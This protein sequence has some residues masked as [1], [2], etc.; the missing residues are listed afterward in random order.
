MQSTSKITIILDIVAAVLGIIYRIVKFIVRFIVLIFTAL[1][2]LSKQ[3]RTIS[4]GFSPKYLLIIAFSFVMFAPG[5]L[6]VKAYFDENKQ[7]VTY[8]TLFGD[9]PVW[10][11]NKVVEKDKNKALGNWSNR[12][13][14]KRWLFAHYNYLLWKGR[15]SA[16]LE[17]RVFRSPWIQNLPFVYKSYISESKVDQIMDNFKAF[18]SYYSKKGID[19]YVILVCWST[20]YYPERLPCDANGAKN[21]IKYNLD[22]QTKLHDELLKL[23]IGNSNLYSLFIKNRDKY[24]FGQWYD[25]HWSPTAAFVA[26]SEMTKWV[27]KKYNTSPVDWEDFKYY[28]LE[29]PLYQSPYLNAHGFNDF[30]YLENSLNLHAM[31]SNPVYPDIYEK[32][33]KPWDEVEPISEFSG[34]KVVYNDIFSH[35]VNKDALTD[36]KVL[37]IGHSYRGFGFINNI[38]RYFCEGYTYHSDIGLNCDNIDNLMVDSLEDKLNFKPDVVIYIM[39]PDYLSVKRCQASN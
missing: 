14:M 33:Q 4:F 39:H 22:L 19:V 28:D 12:I 20:G 7:E 31:Q 17:N 37:L 30:K 9:F 27:A 26:F 16:V 2:H 5:Y 23:N 34:A 32:C 29:N 15:M 3:I 10:L 24:N 18:H 25:P 35:F 8:T 1:W 13:P 38:T 21:V 36:K 11:Y 6:I